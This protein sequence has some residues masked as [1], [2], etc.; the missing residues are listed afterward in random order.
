MTPKIEMLLLVTSLLCIKIGGGE[1]NSPTHLFISQMSVTLSDFY[2]EKGRHFPLVYIG[3]PP[4]T[5]VIVWIY[6]IISLWKRYWYCWNVFL[7]RPY[8]S[9]KQI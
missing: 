2:F 3:D 8:P 9:G 7:E 5:S 4:Q 1:M 6:S